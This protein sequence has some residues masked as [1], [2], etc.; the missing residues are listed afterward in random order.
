MKTMATTM[1]TARAMTMAT[2]WQATKRATTRVARATTTATKRAMMMAAGAMVMA[3][4]EDKGGK[5]KGHG[6]K[7]VNA[8][9]ML[10][11]GRQHQ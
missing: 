9:D 3:I 4:N 5:G 2:R 6:N 1:V 7:G 10:G 11:K 8:R